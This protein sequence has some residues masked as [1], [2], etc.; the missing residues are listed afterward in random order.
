MYLINFLSYVN[1][2][3]IVTLAFIAIAFIGDVIGIILY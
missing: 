2:F 1:L 3:V